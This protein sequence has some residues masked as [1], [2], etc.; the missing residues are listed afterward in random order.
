MGVMA[1]CIYFE[2]QKIEY[3]NSDEVYTQIVGKLNETISQDRDAPNRRTLSLYIVSGPVCRRPECKYAKD[4]GALFYS[5]NIN[6][7]EQ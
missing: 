5:P 3:S 1:V 4:E 6:N 7:L 2:G